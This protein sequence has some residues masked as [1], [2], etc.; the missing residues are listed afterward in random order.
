MCLAELSIFSRRFPLKQYG[1]DITKCAA[2]DNADQ[3]L[4][5]SV[6]KMEYFYLLEGNQMDC[7]TLNV[8]EFP[9]LPVPVL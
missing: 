3:Q 8:D 1:G 6:C 2:L 5:A 7:L 9:R 4:P